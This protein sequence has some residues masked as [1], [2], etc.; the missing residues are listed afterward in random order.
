MRILKVTLLSLV[1]AVMSAQA[2]E[3]TLEF[4]S[5]CLDLDANEVV[6]S[7]PRAT[8]ESAWDVFVAYRSDE[9]PHAVMFHNLRSGVE[10]AILQDRDYLE[11]TAADADAATFSPDVQDVPFRASDVIL[12][13]T[14][15][16]QVFKLGLPVES[17]ENLRFDYS[18]L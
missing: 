16:G 18:A 5:T 11:V 2:A 1:C 4:E 17:D 12:I 6:A 15:L 9:T 3:V 10:I 13:R 7:C 8:D 14:D